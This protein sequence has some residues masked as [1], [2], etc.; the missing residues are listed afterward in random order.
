VKGNIDF[1]KAIDLMVLVVPEAFDLLDEYA[2][3]AFLNLE[4]SSLAH[5]ATSKY[6]ITVEIGHNSAEGKSAHSE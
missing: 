3:A 5:Y 2:D 4:D 1:L 6:L